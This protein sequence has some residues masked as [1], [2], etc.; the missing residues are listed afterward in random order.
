M[1]TQNK[2]LEWYTT[3]GAD[4]LIGEKPINW[5]EQS[6]QYAPPEPVKQTTQSAV[7]IA[8][9]ALP[10]NLLKSAVDAART[11]NTLDELRA[12]LN[13]F[14][15]CALKK[16]AMHTVFGEGETNNHPVMFVGEAPGADEDRLGR[17]FVGVSGQLL[18][19]ILSA[20]GFSRA[21]NTYIANMLPW[22]PPGNRSPSS[23]EITLC[24]PFI[25]RQIELIK[26][27]ILVLV[28]G[29]ALGALT[30]KPMGITKIRGVWLEYHSEGLEAP[31]PMM[32]ILHPAFLLRSPA[33][34]VHAWHD[35]LAIRAK[36]DSLN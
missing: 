10:D 9:V 28:G 2:I 15:G 13:T 24:M 35:V 5:F 1:I 19:K 17:P 36:W 32:A 18:D 4:E 21:K 3:A 16:T 6:A 26:P 27:K 12:A 20:G 23:V 31:I 30:G 14:D 22:R 33:Q 25:K 11:A 7:Q 34:K 29:V 8:P